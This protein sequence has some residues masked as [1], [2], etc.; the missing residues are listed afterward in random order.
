[1]KCVAKSECFSIVKW[2]YYILDNIYIPELAF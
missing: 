2:R 1:M